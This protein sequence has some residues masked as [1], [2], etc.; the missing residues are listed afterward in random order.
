MNLQTEKTENSCPRWEIA[1]YVDGELS[2]R[3]ELEL[4][5]HFSVCPSCAAELNEQK[6]MLC[7]LD[8]AFEKDFQLPADFTKT[9]VIKAESNVKGLRCP[10]E[11]SRA[12]FICTALLILTILG[13]GSEAESVFAAFTTFFEQIWTVAGFAAHLIY[14]IAFGLTVI[15]RSI[16]HQFIFNSVFVLLTLAGFL[17]TFLFFISR[18][19][20]GTKI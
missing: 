10:K 4:E 11:R 13:L 1:A 17:A 15:L 5:G 6:K 19:A 12:L 9:V 16:G 3:E 2:P 8:S 7:A 18:F 14:D 20:P